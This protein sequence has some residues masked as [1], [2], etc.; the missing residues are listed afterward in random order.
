MSLID[1][2]ARFVGST[3]YIITILPGTPTDNRSLTFPNKDG[4]LACL[5]DVEFATFADVS[6]PALSDYLY[7]YDV[8]SSSYRKVLVSEVLSLSSGGA[9][10]YEESYLLYP[11]D[12]LTITHASDPDFRRVPYAVLD[13]IPSD[14]LVL[15]LSCEGSDGGTSLVDTSYYAH[16]IQFSGHAQVDTSQ[17]KHG[18]SSL[19]LDGSGDYI[20]IEGAL[21]EFTFDTGD[22]TISFWIRFASLSGVQGIVDFRPSTTQGAYPCLYY[23]GSTLRLHVSA[24]DQIVGG[25]I[26]ADTWYHVALTRASGNTRLFIDG[27]QVGSTWSDSNNYGCGYNRPW[28]GSDSFNGQSCF[29]GWLDDIVFLKGQALWVESFTP[30][31]ALY[32]PTPAIKGPGL[33]SCHLIGSQD[34]DR[35]WVRYDDGSG[36]SEATKTTFK[37]TTAH[38]VRGIFG[39]RL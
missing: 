35:I 5:S 3:G 16:T 11:S 32:S 23:Y 1:T 13:A 4:V 20:Y 28:L 15:C 18:T 39:V 36:G 24:V 38:P 29:N 10:Y 33:L 37:N 8:S 26:S 25:D 19:L 30:P 2:N 34:A 31:T 17:Y 22:F 9:V 6:E 27:T 21:P 7:L 12:S 14:G